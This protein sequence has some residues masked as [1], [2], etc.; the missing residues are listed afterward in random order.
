[1]QKNRFKPSALL[2]AVLCAL[3]SNLYAADTLSETVVTAT[4]IE[5]PLRNALNHTTVLT[6][7]DIVASQAVDVPT[8]LQTLAGVETYQSGGV[9][10]QSSLFLRGANSNQV[11]VLLDGVR[12]NSATTGSTATDQL[13]LDQIERI[14]VVRGNVSSLYGSEAI[15]G[16][17]QVFTKRGKGAPA[18]EMS[19]G[20][21][22]HGTQK[23]AAGLGGKMDAT[24]FNV[25]LSGFKTDGVSAIKSS[26]VPAVN[27]DKDGYRNSSVSANVRHAFNANHSVVASVFQSRGRVKFDDAFALP[28]DVNSSTSEL[29]KFALASEHR[30]ADIWLSKLQWAQGSDDLKTYLNGLPEPFGGYVKTQNRQLGWQN[31]IALGANHLLLA[32]MEN[33]RQKV[34]SDTAYSQTERRIQAVF[35]GYTGNY[36]AHQVQA[37]VRQDRYSDF[38][39]ANTGLL[40]YGYTLTS[41]LRIT[42]NASTAFKAPTFTDLYGPVFW[43]SNAKLQAERSRHAEIGVHYSADGQQ[44][45]AV[46]FT[47]RTHDLIAADNKFVLQNIKSA[48]NDG[49][50]LNYGGRFGDTAVK[51]AATLQNPRDSQTGQ[52]LLRRA[53]SFAHVGVTQKMAA[54][55]LGGELQYSAGRMDA[56]ILSG[57]RTSLSGYSVV[58]LTAKYALQKSLALSVSVSNV[59][60]RD[61]MIAHGYNTLGRTLFVGLHYR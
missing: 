18:L 41:A 11:L 38:G 1:M 44:L 21:G 3:N 36:D 58:N 13:M 10:K 55:Q 54:W 6:Q 59:F 51:F 12:I 56:D 43:G 19:G 47:S 53:R 20:L 17:I 2:A 7:E 30:V 45:D 29:S 28:A 24:D 39:V 9:G 61:Y 23:L 57:A 5:Q 32:G 25:Q 40:G 15:G 27:P 46:Y 35:T 31:E 14:E 34:S 26:I 48:R 4:R 8:L 33:L 37:N 50:E 22:T 42:A 60:N 49:L 16:V 52:A